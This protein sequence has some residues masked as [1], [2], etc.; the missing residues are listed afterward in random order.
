MTT[1]LTSE[2]VAHFRRQGYLAARPMLTAEEVSRFRGALEAFEAAQGATLGEL[3]GQL[4][5]KT[6]LLFTWMDELVRHPNI[7]DAVEGLIGPD[8][9]VYHL[10]CWLKEAHSS[11][12]VSWHQDGTYFGLEPAEH[13]TAWVALSEASEDS[14]CMRALPGSHLR[15]QL[16]H[17]GGPTEN[18]L[19]SNGQIVR[20]VVPDG[21]EV[22]LAMPAGHVSFH[23]THLVH[24]SGP[25]STDGRRIGIGISYIPTRVYH[26]G[27]VRQSALLVRGS[28][29]YGHFDHETSPRADFDAAARAHHGE[30]CARFFSDH[31]SRRTAG[32]A[33]G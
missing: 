12:Y 29:D 4:R 2:D 25:N 6:Y 30:A 20:G 26:T 8:I 16:V 27:E 24:A 19:L 17:D 5:A 10:T 23:H 11:S 9:L 3:P 13:V 7:L 28:D 31:G 1:S 32:E 33:A 22:V 18:N 15:G 14:G 21:G